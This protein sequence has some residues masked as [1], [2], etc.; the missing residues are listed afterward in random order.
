MNALTRACELSI[1]RLQNGWREFKADERG[2]GLVSFLLIAVAVAAIALF[3]L[4]VF[5]GEI[6]DSIDEF[7]MGD[8]PAPTLP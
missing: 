1:V 8:V 4:G 7:D 6:I 2:D 3:V 5:E